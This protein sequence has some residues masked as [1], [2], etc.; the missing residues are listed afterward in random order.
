M[1]QLHLLQETPLP[2]IS[3]VKGTTSKLVDIFAQDSSVTTGAG[4]TGLVFNTASL[5]AYYYL[6]GAASAVAIS[7]VTMT[8]GTWTSGGF[9]VVDGTNMPGVYQIG[10]P[11]AALTGAN[12]VVVYV[13]GATNMAPCVLE[14]ELT[15]VNNQDATVFG[16]TGLLSPT[17]AGRTLDVSA[18]GEAGLDW[19]NVGSKTTTNALTNTTVLIDQ[20]AAVAQSDVSALT[21][22]TVGAALASARAQGAGA[23]AISGTTL[24]LKNPDGTTFRTFT[25]DSATAPTSRT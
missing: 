4:L 21:T 9:K 2:K 5:Q 18:T 10:L 19:G 14:I 7:L 11:N 24:T 15:A 12:S 23:W 20:S 22:S 16:T 8:L 17:V 25:L 13:F 3:I 6:E 1:Q